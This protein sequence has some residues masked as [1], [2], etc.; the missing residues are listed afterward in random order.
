MFTLSTTSPTSSHE[1]D[2]PPGCRPSGPAARTARLVVYMST[3]AILSAGT[4]LTLEGDLSRSISSRALSEVGAS[5]SGD[6]RVGPSGAADNFRCPRG[7]LRVDSRDPGHCRHRSDHS[8]SA[9]AGSCAPSRAEHRVAGT[10]AAGVARATRDWSIPVVWAAVRP[11]DAAGIICRTHDDRVALSWEV[12]VSGRLAADNALLEIPPTGP[13]GA[14][15]RRPEEH[16]HPRQ[17]G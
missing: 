10:S 17:F 14:V 13:V 8:G 12:G 3:T 6:A 16:G 9:V 15:P 11:I 5:S 4:S 2:R 1:S 7:P